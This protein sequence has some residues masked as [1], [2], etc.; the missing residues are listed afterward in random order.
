MLYFY[1]CLL[2]SNQGT[3][4]ILTRPKCSISDSLNLRDTLV[5]L[6]SCVNR[7]ILFEILQLYLYLV[8][9]SKT[10][11]GILPGVQYGISYRLNIESPS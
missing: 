1:P 9:L 2:D 5:E 8:Y 3:P 10:T 11:T 4:G 6:Y 7:H